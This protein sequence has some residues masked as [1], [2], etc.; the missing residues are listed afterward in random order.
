VKHLKV[1]LD[2]LSHNFPDDIDVLLVGPGGQALKLMS[3]AG[4]GGVALRLTNVVL[5]FS[6]T[7]TQL[8]PDTT[9]IFPGEYA[10][11]DYGPADNFPPPAPASVTATNFAP[12]LGTNPNGIWSL[13]VRDDLG[14]DAGFIARGWILN[15]EWEDTAPSLSAPA[16]LPDGRFAMTL[17]GLPHMT[18]VIEASSD[19]ITWFPVSTNTPSAASLILFDSRSDDAPYRFYRAVRCP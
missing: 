18:H 17:T 12:F 11:T 19:L 14:G 2:G 13:F 3:D 7:A 9:L 6:D 5:G 1:T 16:L 15:V 10:P 8:L 4:G